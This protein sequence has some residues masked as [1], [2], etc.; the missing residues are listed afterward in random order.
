MQV[1][2]AVVAAIARSL[3]RMPLAWFVGGPCADLL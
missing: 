1:A 2:M 3:R